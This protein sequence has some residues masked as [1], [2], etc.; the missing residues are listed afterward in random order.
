MRLL[1]WI[2]R[3]LLFFALFAFALNN[4]QDAVI[5]W[6]FGTQWQAPMVIVVL[7]AFALGCALGVVAMVPAWWRQRRE[8][9]RPM[10]AEPDLPPMPA[11]HGAEF[12]TPDHPPR[13]GL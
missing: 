13:T 2:V 12:T 1:V 5:H 8:A 7:G 3:A 9:Q 10:V 11:P 6:F 4:Q